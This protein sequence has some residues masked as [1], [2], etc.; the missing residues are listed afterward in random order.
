MKRGA[1]S[2]AS[3]LTNVPSTSAI[4]DS[5]LLNR[6]PGQVWSVDDQC[7]MIYGID[8]RFARFKASSV[9]GGLYCFKTTADA[10]AV[11]GG[12]AADGTSC[13]SGSVSIILKNC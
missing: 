7:K 5:Y 8:A 4:D 9:C 10:S 12:A 1:S 3:C 11:S 6:L 13:G 2:K